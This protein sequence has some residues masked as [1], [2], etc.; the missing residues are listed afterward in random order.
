MKKLFLYSFI[1]VLTLVFFEEVKAEVKLNVPFSIQ[2]PYGH[3]VAPWDNACEETSTVMIDK[4]YQ[5][6]P[7]RNLP[8]EIADVLIIKGR[9]EEIKES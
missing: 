5:N 8:A 3:W 6:Y 9:V 1:F 4:Y 2:A 7:G